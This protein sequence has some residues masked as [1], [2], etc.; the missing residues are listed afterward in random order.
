MP[1]IALTT[2]NQAEA[3][4][5]GDAVR[6]FGATVRLLTPDL[7]S[8]KP[9]SLLD[10][11]GALLLSGGADIH[12]Q[13]YGEAPRPDAHLDLE[14]ARDELEFNVLAEALS[15]D[16]P[17]LAICRGMQLLNV[18]MGGK[19]TQHLEGHHGPD[20]TSSFHHIFISPGC[21]LAMLVGAG[22]MV[23]VNS[24]H[25]QGFKDAHRST[26]LLTSAYSLEDRLVEGLESPDHSWV[27][28]IQCHPEIA[29]EVPKSFQRMFEV[30]VERAEEFG[31]G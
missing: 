7:A 25:H 24:R 22:G 10:G 2:S 3:K 18:H 23:R 27:I 21:K 30:F 12:P 14:P 15:R 28:G 8:Q 19:L 31:E 5:Y 6:A 17:V 4:P 29:T 26:K 20:W 16:M 11:A 1:T 13:R 9:S